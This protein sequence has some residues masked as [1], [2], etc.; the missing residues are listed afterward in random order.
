MYIFNSFY[1]VH[2]YNPS[3]LICLCFNVASFRDLGA[4][5]RPVS[6]RGLIQNFWRASPALS[7]AESPAPGILMESYCGTITEPG[8]PVGLPGI[9]H[10][11]LL[12]CENVSLDW[13]TMQLV[14][15]YGCQ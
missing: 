7:Y 1:L 10:Y 13:S 12:I 4:T 11:I 3:F 9:I 6:I 5:P 14:G 8:L 15:N 2:S